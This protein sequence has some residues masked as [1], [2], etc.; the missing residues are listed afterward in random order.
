MKYLLLLVWAFVLSPGL[1]AQQEYREVVYVYEF[2]YASYEPAEKECAAGLAKLED[3]SKISGINLT[4]TGKFKIY[5]VG[6]LAR[7]G[8][9]TDHT[10]TEIGETFVCLDQFTYRSQG[11]NL[12]PLYQE[13]T[14]GNRTYKIEGGG[15]HADS[16]DRRYGGVSHIMGGYPASDSLWETV[17]GTVLPSRP[18][19]D[20]DSAVTRGGVLVGS[21]RLVFD[22]NLQIIPSL[23]SS[24]SILRVILPVNS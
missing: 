10:V 7:K 22:E 19:V 11:E 23:S 20:A 24:T 16:P 9:V 1:N 17:T 5:S 13:V 6:T 2:D 15:I 12:S 21:V 3:K 4:Y 8:K 14:I 18:S